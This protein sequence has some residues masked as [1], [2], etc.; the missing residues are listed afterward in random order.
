MKSV[1]LMFFGGLIGGL[2]GPVTALA[3]VA[4][5]YLVGRALTHSA[6]PNSGDEQSPYR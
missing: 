5:G 3:G 2:I 1:V 4:T 6:A